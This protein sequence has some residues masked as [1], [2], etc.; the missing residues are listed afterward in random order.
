MLQRVLNV[1]HMEQRQFRCGSETQR[2]MRHIVHSVHEICKCLTLPHRTRRP[3]TRRKGDRGLQPLLLP[4]HQPLLSPEPQRAYTH[5]PWNRGKGGA[6]PQART[7]GSPW[8]RGGPPPTQG[9]Y[10]WGRGS[11]NPFFGINFGAKNFRNFMPKKKSPKW[12]QPGSCTVGGPLLITRQKV[13]WKNRGA[14]RSRPR[15][16]VR[17]PNSSCCSTVSSSCRTESTARSFHHLCSSQTDD[18]NKI[19]AYFLF[20][21]INIIY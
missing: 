9:G 2:F 20:A 7:G 3:G 12:P 14:A 4:L 19:I 18:K 10:P 21:T 5:G 6:H 13:L 8:G 17:M 16:S 15:S 1:L 11:G